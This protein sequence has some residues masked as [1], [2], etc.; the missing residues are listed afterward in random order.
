[1]SK[2]HKSFYEG[3]NPP[4]YPEGSYAYEEWWAEQ[5]R[6]CLEGYKVDAEHWIT[7]MHYYYINFCKIDRLNEEGVVVFDYP[8]YSTIDHELYTYLYECKKQGKGFMLLTARGFGKS[9]F[10]SSV[11]DYH[12]TFFPKSE[13]IVSA[14]IELYANKLWNKIKEMLEAKEEFYHAKLI[15]NEFKIISGY[16][17]KNERNEERIGGY[18]SKIEKVI[19]ENKAGK[20]RGGRPTVHVFEEVGAWTGGASLKDCYNMS[21][22]SWW[23]GKYFTCLPILIGTGGEMKTGGTADAKEMFYNPD[24]FN[25][26]AF[27][28][29]ETQKKK[30]FFVPAY[31]KAEGFY[32]EYG[33]RTEEAK[34]FFEEQRALKESE[35]E[36]YEQYIQEYPFTENEM[37]YSS[38]ESPFA[39][40]QT[41]LYE[42]EMGI[43]TRPY[44]RGYMRRSSEGH[45]EFVEHKDGAIILLEDPVKGRDGTIPENLYVAGIDSYDQSVAYSS[46]S[47][48]AMA[49]F[50]RQYGTSGRYFVGLYYDRPQDVYEFYE[51]CMLL[52]EYFNIKYNVLI[53]YTRIGIIQYF[54]QHNKSL[55]LARSP[56][57]AYNSIK[58]SVARNKYGFQMNYHTK[59]YAVDLYRNYC[60]ENKH[61]FY[62]KEMVEDHIEF[63]M[64]E[65]KFD[66]T[67]AAMLALVQDV[68]LTEV[69]VEEMTHPR[70]MPRWRRVNGKFVFE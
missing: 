68:E 50:K 58:R 28:D 24:E 3:R 55:Y 7:G 20:T 42:L 66:I 56:E 14:S 6:R 48:G 69:K 59:V 25:L 27:K 46:E 70:R 67:I 2:F 40:L 52:A 32:D 18:Q 13:C 30:C 21:S 35:R 19:Y 47:K 39:F 65:G 51:Q 45:A 54:E 1:M 53:E 22:A 60:I 8:R 61:L 15:A 63:N 12:F 34:K 11:V 10:V 23:R 49:I 41:R 43:D 64:N 17:Y 9:Y 31:V 44:K 16:R 36:V 26:L 37:F 4:D 33:I 38:N 62:I 5:K 29:P 57:S